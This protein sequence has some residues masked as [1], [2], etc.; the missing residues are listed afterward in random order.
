MA[1]L[2]SKQVAAV[3]HAVTNAAPAGTD[4]ALIDRTSRAIC[5]HATVFNAGRLATER[6]GT[7]PAL[8]SLRNI[9]RKIDALT[10]AIEAI[11]ADEQIAL[12]SRSSEA[13]PP[14]VLADN[15]LDTLNEW[16]KRV[17][18]A[19]AALSSSSDVP[20]RPKGRPPDLTSHAIAEYAARRYH[21]LTGIAPARGYHDCRSEFDVFMDE[22]CRALGLPLSAERLAR[23]VSERRSRGAAR[24]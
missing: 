7:K 23:A 18:S 5:L 15:M 20:T 19:S 14:I 2:T 4:P 16:A 11:G 3:W 17:R 24:S 1:G 12:R 8:A 9:G 13:D 10:A 22:I 6:R 21:F